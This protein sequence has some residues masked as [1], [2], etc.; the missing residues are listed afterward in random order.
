MN[1]NLTIEN[2]DEYGTCT[3][4]EKKPDIELSVGGIWEERERYQSD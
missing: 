3:L 4:V 1:D 2:V